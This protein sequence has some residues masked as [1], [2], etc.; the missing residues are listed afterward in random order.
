MNDSASALVI[1]VPVPVRAAHAKAYHV[2]V[3]ISASCN[4]SSK[5]F[6]TQEKVICYIELCYLKIKP[7]MAVLLSKKQESGV[8]S[9][10]LR[11]MLDS[12]I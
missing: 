5:T 10:E 6:D 9:K 2:R 1:L 7:K 8:S 11:M 4:L 12:Y 3:Q